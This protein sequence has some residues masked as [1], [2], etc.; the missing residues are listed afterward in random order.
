MTYTAGGGAPM[1]DT[2][3]GST[4]S[5]TAPA[6]CA[7]AATAARDWGTGARTFTLD[8]YPRLQ[9]AANG[10]LACANCHTTGGVAAVLPFDGP[11]QAT[12]DAIRARPG[13]VV[14]ATPATSMLLTKPLKPGIPQ[15]PQRHV[16]NASGLDYIVI[17]QWIEQGAAL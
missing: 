13:V 14:L 10:G 7:A 5:P 15:P 4:P 6:S 17:L 8:V 11:I 1:T 16:P 2:A 3:D 12:Y 9:T